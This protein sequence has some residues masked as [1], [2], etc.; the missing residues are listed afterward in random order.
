M[1]PDKEIN[2]TLWALRVAAVDV[3]DRV[4]PAAPASELNVIEHVLSPNVCVLSPVAVRL[5]VAKFVSIFA[6][7]VFFNKPVT[8]S[9]KRKISVDT[10]IPGS[11]SGYFFKVSVVPSITIIVGIS[12]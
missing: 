9:P 2:K 5:L 11:N 12:V 10:G 1:A 6:R 3:D 8:G 4:R 7:V